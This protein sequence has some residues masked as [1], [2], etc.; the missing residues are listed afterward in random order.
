M[1]CVIEACAQTK[2][3]PQVACQCS[4]LSPICQAVME[5]SIASSAQAA[6]L[7]A[8]LSHEQ[9]ICRSLPNNILQQ[10]TVDLRATA[11][12]TTCIA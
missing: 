8:L 10:Q 2:D 1:Q 7:C 4:A 11:A 5:G 12:I 9:S 6:Q 3:V